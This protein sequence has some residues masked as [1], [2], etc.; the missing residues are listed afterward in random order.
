MTLIDGALTV[1][2]V[3]RSTLN[4]AVGWWWADT[5]SSME[6]ERRGHPAGRALTSQ[7]NMSNQQFL[8]DHQCGGQQQ[9]RS[10]ELNSRRASTP[11]R[12]SAFGQKAVEKIAGLEQFLTLSWARARP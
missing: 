3:A 11:T 9:Q 5:T 6:H 7:L 8:G 2:V 12:L 10:G 1:A 4:L